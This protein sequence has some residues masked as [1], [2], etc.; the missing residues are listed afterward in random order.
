MLVHRISLLLLFLPAASRGAEDAR[1]EDRLI[2]WGLALH[3]REIDPTP[4]GKRIDEII[5]ASEEIVAPSDPWPGI[6]NIV[7]VKTKPTVI[8]GEL[9]FAPGEPYRRDLI[10]ESERNLRRIFILGVARIVPVKSQQ[11]GVVSVLVITKDLWS[12]RLN[13]EFNFVGPLLQL[14]WLRPTEHNLLGRNKQV[15]LDLELK[16]D[17][18]SIGQGYADPR[19]LGSRLTFLERAAVIFNRRTGMAEGSRGALQI[20]RPLYSLDTEWGFSA[21]AS[22]RIETTRIFRGASIWAL[23]YPDAET[24]TSTVPYVYRTRSVIAEGLYTRSYGRQYKTNIH[25]GIGGF[26]RRYGPPS[27]SGLDEAQTAW[28]QANYAPRSENASYLT[29]AFDLFESNYIVLRDIDVFALSEDYQL[30]HRVSGT[31]R[32]ANRAFL[33]PNDFLEGSVSSRYRWY[34][35]GDL[36]TLS[37]G[38]SIRYAPGSNVPNIST[39]WVNRRLALQV[40]NAFPPLW[41]GRI[42]ARGLWDMRGADL[43]HRIVLLGGGNGIRGIA[44][45]QLFG[46]NQILL[47]VE[48]RTR[49]LEIG[50][51][52]VGL[53]LFWDAGSAYNKDPSLIHTVGIGLRALFPQFNVDCLRLDFGYALNGPSTAFLNHISGS[54]GQIT[55]YRPALLDRPD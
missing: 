46:T 27:S 44:A 31:V 26:T 42:V 6:L 18:L 39:R 11:P 4:D 22:W 54:F 8:R 12:I 7:H 24:P 32:W 15:S 49:P 53:V 47:N 23:P 17:T 30:G 34:F 5:V 51:L 14:L 40:H 38:A 55:E 37:A 33:S 48:Y 36:L 21:A 29:A 9:L 19:V 41:I 10:E 2:E 43:N 52:H 20:G 35:G 1:Y 16:L 25:A 28:F 3:H 13:T 45:E 50:T